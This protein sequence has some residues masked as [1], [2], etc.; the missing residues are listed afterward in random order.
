MRR[1]LLINQHNN[2]RDF[3]TCINYFDDM[4]RSHFRS[5]DIRP[6]P[7]QDVAHERTA[8]ADANV[9]GDEDQ[10]L[11]ASRGGRGGPQIDR[12]KM[13]NERS[14]W[15]C[16]GFGH[17]AEDCPSEKGFRQISDAMYLLSTMLPRRGE[18]VQD[19]AVMDVAVLGEVR[20]A[21][22]IVGS[23]TRESC[24]TRA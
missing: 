22:Q 9:A 23:T 7:R 21:A 12:A 1:A 19:E 15:N 5:G 4:W 2:G 24:S 16:R 11:I 18:A 20:G 3:Q 13:S 8:R 14:C 6:R 17:M 10:A